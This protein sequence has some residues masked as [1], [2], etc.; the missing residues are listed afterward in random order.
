MSEF[1]KKKR[2]R[3][4]WEFEEQN[5]NW[6]SHHVEQKMGHRLVSNYLAPAE[7]MNLCKM[8]VKYREVIFPNYKFI[9]STLNAQADRQLQHIIDQSAIKAA[10][11]RTETING[12]IFSMTN[13][14]YS[15]G[16]TL[17]AAVRNPLGGVFNVSQ[18]AMQNVTAMLLAYISLKAVTAK[19]YAAAWFNSCSSLILFSGVIENNTWIYKLRWRENWC[20]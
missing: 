18:N 17:Q 2:E 19:A 7:F 15:F 5:Q 12:A 4:G 8:D 9:E 3:M 13:L 16:Q 1:I 20:S 10:A 14:K 6:V 11:R